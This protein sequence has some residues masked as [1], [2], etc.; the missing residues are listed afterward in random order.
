MVRILITSLELKIVLK[1]LLASFFSGVVGFEREIR[2]KPAGIKTHL[3]VGLGSGIFT[4]LALLYFKSPDATSR[5]VANILTG[6]GFIG[7]GTIFK[8]RHEIEGITTAASLWVV[9][10]LSAFTVLGN[11]LI[12]FALT[13]LIVFSLEMGR[14]LEGKLKR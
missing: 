1:L 13:C 4:A 7:A 3:L 10:A 14:W 5:I 12:S 6:M 11:P 2:K 8:Y 9:S